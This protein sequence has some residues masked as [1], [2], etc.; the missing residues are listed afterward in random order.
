MKMLSRKPARFLL[1]AAGMTV[2]LLFS[3]PAGLRAQ[4]TGSISGSIKD[5]SGAAIPGAKV[6]AT[7]VTQNFSTSVDSNSEGFYQFTA[8]Q[9]GAYTVT[10]EKTGFSRTTHT[11]V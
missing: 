5:P 6:T 10:V 1:W 3:L 4:V 11:A 8:L 7:L 9:P 2:C